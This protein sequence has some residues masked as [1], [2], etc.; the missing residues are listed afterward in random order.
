MSWFSKVW[1]TFGDMDTQK[2]WGADEGPEDEVEYVH[3]LERFGDA[4]YRPDGK[5]KRPEDF[6]DF[7][8]RDLAEQVWREGEQPR[9][10]FN[11]LLLTEERARERTPASREKGPSQTGLWGRMGQAADEGAA[12]LQQ[13]ADEHIFRPSLETFDEYGGRAYQ[14][15]ERT[16]VPPAE[17]FLLGAKAKGEEMLGHLKAG[18]SLQ[19]P[20]P[21]DYGGAPMLSPPVEP[22]GTPGRDRYAAAEAARAEGQRRAQEISDTA[23]DQLS[24]DAGIAYAQGFGYGA[25]GATAEEAATALLGVPGKAVKGGLK[26]ARATKEFLDM[27]T[28]VIK[29][30]GR[31]GTVDPADV[32]AGP[33]AREA[34]SRL[35]KDLPGL[36][37]K[38]TPGGWLLKKAT[39]KGAKVLINTAADAAHALGERSLADAH[40]QHRGVLLGSVGPNDYVG[41][42]VDAGAPLGMIQGDLLRAGVSPE[43]TGRLMESARRRKERDQ[44]QPGRGGGG[45]GLYG[46]PG[47]RPLVQ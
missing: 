29:S 22:R 41:L 34:L 28:D 14:A 42:M 25:G 31:H 43:F 47:Q 30:I 46:T 6:T 1:S 9:G 5:L 19:G 16:V 17:A 23:V 27:G 33:V 3:F 35:E 4:A 40:P 12:W 39:K 10:E 44:L 24:P 15:L 32:A 2:S 36:A 38:G 8:H 21:A 13:E 7:R 26:G 11:E 18:V 20:G 45:Y 37:K